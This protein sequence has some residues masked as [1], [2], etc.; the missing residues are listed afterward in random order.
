MFI[1]DHS[2]GLLGGV[3]SQGSK[4]EVKVFTH[5]STDVFFFSAR[6]VEEV[7]FDQLPLAGYSIIIHLVPEEGP[8]HNINTTPPPSFA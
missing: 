1:D 7:C 3:E 4:N 6:A 8:S 2:I 5:L